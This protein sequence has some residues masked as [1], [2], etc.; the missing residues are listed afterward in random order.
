MR[1]EVIRGVS[2]IQPCDAYDFGATTLNYVLENNLTLA[3]AF[4][5]IDQKY[6]S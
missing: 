3:S 6:A 1:H 2:A 4:L 5:L